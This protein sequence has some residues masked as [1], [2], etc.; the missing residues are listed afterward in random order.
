[1]RSPVRT[2]RRYSL[3]SLLAECDAAAP[4]PECLRG[5][6]DAPAKG[7]EAWALG[8]DQNQLGGLEERRKTPGYQIRNS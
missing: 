6:L 1:M 8:I 4:F 3:E 2:D 5:W 7:D